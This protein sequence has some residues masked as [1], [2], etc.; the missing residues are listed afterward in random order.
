MQKKMRMTWEKD[1][2]CS[3]S[4]LE[5]SPVLRIRGV[6]DG[7]LNDPGP[8]VFPKC[9]GHFLHSFES[10]S[11]KTSFNPRDSPVGTNMQFSPQCNY[12]K[13]ASGAETPQCTF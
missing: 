9:E 3:F 6:T 2:P 11:Q 5:R 10:C 13:G 8:H 1:P 12:K 4:S 7:S